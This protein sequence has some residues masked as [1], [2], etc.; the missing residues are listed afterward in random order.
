MPEIKILPI[1]KSVAIAMVFFVLGRLM[2]IQLGTLGVWIT[3]ILVIVFYAIWWVRYQ[4][5]KR[6]DR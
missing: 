6:R 1:V 3:A 4:R 2:V 5:E